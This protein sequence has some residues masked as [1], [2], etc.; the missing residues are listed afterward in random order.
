MH[1]TDPGAITGYHAHVYFDEQSIDGARRLCEEAQ[2]RFGATMGRMHEKP[3]GPHPSWSCQLAFAPALFDQVVPWLALNRGPL[4][5]LVHPET[6]DHLRDHRD[7][8]LWM[9]QVMPLKLSIFTRE[10]GE[11]A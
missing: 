4:I 5:I 9:G 2:R 10:Q 6:G 11:D 3:V 7:H 8:A 1:D